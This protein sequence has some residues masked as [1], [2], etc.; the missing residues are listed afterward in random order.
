MDPGRLH[1]PKLIAV[2]WTEVQEILG[3][4]ASGQRENRAQNRQSEHDERHVE[5]AASQSRLIRGCDGC[6]RIHFDL[7]GPRGASS[8]FFAYSMAV[9]AAAINP[10]LPALPEPGHGLYRRSSLGDMGVLLLRLQIRV[11]VHIVLS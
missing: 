3:A 2:L 9:G 7:P 10:S 4:E 1:G 11:P 6:L 8:L 5:D